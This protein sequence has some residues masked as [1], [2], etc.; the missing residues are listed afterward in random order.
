ME[1]FVLSVYDRCAGA[2]G[3]P[4]FAL[5]R[6]A[7]IRSFQDEVNRS[8]DDNVMFRHVKDYDLFDLG[9]FDDQT[10]LFSKSSPVLLAVGAQL[11][12]APV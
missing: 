4:V 3:R 5:S 10:G 1:Y 7:A 12:L 11:V 2:Y 9:T 6:G 8:D